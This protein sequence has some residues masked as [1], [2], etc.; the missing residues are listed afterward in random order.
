MTWN[1]GSHC[2][3]TRSGTLFHPPRDSTLGSGTLH[4]ND[5]NVPTWD[6]IPRV[7]KGLFGANLRSF[8]LPAVGRE[9]LKTRTESNDSTLPCSPACSN[10][11]TACKNPSLS[12]PWITHS[13]KTHRNVNLTREKK[14][15]NRKK[16]GELQLTRTSYLDSTDL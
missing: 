4:A 2:S 16:R 1:P 15:N 3:R 8:L 14:K 5:G 13:H 12:T 7:L 11:P 10:T 6:S 9:R